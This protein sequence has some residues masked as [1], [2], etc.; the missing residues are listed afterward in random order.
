MNQPTMRYST[1][2]IAIVTLGLAGCTGDAPS[3]T[4]EAAGSKEERNMSIDPQL[5]PLVS[6]AR[7]DLA[8]RLEVD[9]AEISVIDA[10]FVTWPNSALGC[11][12]PDMMYTQA[13]VPGYRIRLRA[14]GALH[15]YHG[16]DDRPPSHCPA[17]RV[18]EPAA[19]TKNPKDVS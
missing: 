14:D 19:G 18:T 1:L 12:E 5:E 8:R 16:A 7:S 10:G 15:H 17:D 3:G 2:L 9:E 11:P 13:L 6:Q 4:G